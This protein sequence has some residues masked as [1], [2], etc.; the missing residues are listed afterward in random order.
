MRLT[1][2]VSSFA[3]SRAAEIYRGSVLQAGIEDNAKNFTRFLLAAPAG[4]TLDLVP[5]AQ[6]RRWKTSR[7]RGE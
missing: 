1:A 5:D 4:R 7:R 3:S 6:S 2:A